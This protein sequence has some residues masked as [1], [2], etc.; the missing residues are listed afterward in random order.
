MEKDPTMKDPHSPAESMI[1]SKLLMTDTAR[2]KARTFQL[3]VIAVFLQARMRSR[4]FIT[5]P[6]VYGEVVLEF[7]EYCG[8]LVKAK[9][10]M[11]LSG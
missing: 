7:K 3:D 2:H 5:L 11:R 10:G 1:M 9:Y 6:K 8:K 4:V